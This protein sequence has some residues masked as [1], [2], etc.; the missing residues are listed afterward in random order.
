M[1]PGG[2]TLR[3]E[4]APRPYALPE[5]ADPI[6]IGEEKRVVHD[7]ALSEGVSLR[8]TVYYPD[9]SPAS[10]AQL[11]GYILGSSRRLTAESNPI[12]SYTLSAFPVDSEVRIHIRPLDFPHLNPV[13]SIT[14]RMHLTES[15]E[16]YELRIPAEGSVLVKVLSGEGTPLSGQRVRVRYDS[17]DPLEQWDE[18]LAERFTKERSANRQGEAKIDGLTPGPWRARI[19]TRKNPVEGALFVRE[20]ETAELTLTV[21]I[22]LLV[23]NSGILAGLVRFEDGTPAEN[24]RILARMTGDKENI[25][26]GTEGS[27]R[28]DREGRFRIRGLRQGGAF[29]VELRSRRATLTKEG[30]LASNLNLEFVLPNS[31]G[32]SIRVTTPGGD[33][34][35]SLWNAYLF[36][37]EE[38][39]ERY[40]FEPPK[41]DPNPGLARWEALAGGTYQVLI[42][43]PDIPRGYSGP[44]PVGADEMTETIEIRLPEAADFAGEAVDSETLKGISGVE[45]TEMFP[46]G[47]IGSRWPQFLYQRQVYSDR[48]GDFLLSSLPP[49][50]LRIR[51]EHPLY[52]AQVFESGGIPNSETRILMEKKPETGR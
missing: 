3:V 42:A 47:S 9:G 7:I 20:A 11:T 23:D 45:V 39:R 37:L 27:A 15:M 41:P 38:G 48:V 35:R 46:E 17:E 28:T 8:G 5:K 40:I 43:G 16:D 1:S 22:E 6:V 21:P 26:A 10:G 29:R 32:L 25:D 12:G 49:G 14:E 2:Y 18:R 19:E 36:R 51:L 31:G 24:V 33:P 4:S 13:P 34:P 52:K 44:I 50:E 30:I